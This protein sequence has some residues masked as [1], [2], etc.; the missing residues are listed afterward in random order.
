MTFERRRGPFFM[1]QMKQPGPVQSPRILSALCGQS[2]DVFVTLPEGADLLNGLRDAVLTH[3][4]KGAGIT[5]L[6]GRID[7]LHYF[8]GM[9]DPTGRR[10]ATYGEPTP[11]EGPIELLSGNAIIG[12]DAEGNPLVHGHAV[13]AEAT[14]KVHGGHLPPGDCPVG[15]G[16]VRALAVLHDGAVFSVREDQETN[17]S[18]FHPSRVAGEA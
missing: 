1:R 6:G 17:Y 13:M 8:T 11:L 2:R 16:G 18:I 9:P 4:G 10:L 12:E 7:R 15:K 14:G 3:G 5:L